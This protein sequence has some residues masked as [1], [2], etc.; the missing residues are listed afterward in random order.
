MLPPVKIGGHRQ[1][2]VLPR[3]DV[4]PAGEGVIGQGL[5][6]RLVQPHQPDQPFPFLI[7]ADL[8]VAKNGGIAA[9][10]QGGH[11]PAFQVAAQEDGVGEGAA[12]RV[13]RPL[14][15]RDGAEVKGVFRQQVPLPPGAPEGVLRPLLGEIVEKAYLSPL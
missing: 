4:V 7:T 12:L 2:A 5:Q 6:H 15:A 8:T 10:Q 3:P 13:E 9:L 11:C 1:R 14:F